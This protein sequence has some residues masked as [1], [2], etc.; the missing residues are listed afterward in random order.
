M[1]HLNGAYYGPAV[2]PPKSYH[3]PSHGGG[4]GGR[5]GCCC[6]CLS[7]FCGCIFDCILGLICK[8]LTTVIIILAVLAFLFW[9]IVR[10][11]VI[12]FHVTDASLT[13]F[14]YTTNNT[15]HY[16]LTL[17]VSIRNPNR[18]VGVYYD[19]IEALALYE[20]V[21]FGNLTL[22]SFYQHHKN[23]TFVSPIFKGQRV[24][25]LAKVQVSEFDKEKGSGV[26]TIDLKLFMTVRFKFL[27][28]K[29]GSLKPKIRCALHVPLKSRNATTS[30]DAAFQPTECDWDYGKKWWI[31]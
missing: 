22:G 12:K 13:R 31:H 7:C 25:P 30:P 1:S 26:Y 6:G 4:G 16:D 21:L 19:Q 5:D 15:L 10:P 27:L 18:R 8:I 17:N 29:S 23:T 2:P 11:N 3:R 9:F 24:T 14:D 28:F 20:D